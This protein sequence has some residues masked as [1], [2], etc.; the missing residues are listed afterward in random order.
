MVSARWLWRT[1]RRNIFSFIILRSQEGLN[2]FNK[3]YSAIFPREKKK[4]RK[5]SEM[6]L[7]GVSIFWEYEKE[8]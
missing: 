3:D 4:E 1:K 5:K 8:L 7:S 6:K 2:S